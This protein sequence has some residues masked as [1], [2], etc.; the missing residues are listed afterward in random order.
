MWAQNHA[1]SLQSARRRQVL[2]QIALSR[3][4]LA[5]STLTAQQPINNVARV[6]L[7]A[8]AAVLGGTQ[9]LHTNSMDEALALPSQTAAQV[10]LRTQ[11]IIAY[12]TGVAD[13]IDPLAGS[14][15]I[16]SL[17]DQLEARAKA[18]IDQIDALGGALVAIE[19]GFIQQQIQDS[20]YA[21]QQAVERGD[22][23][24]VG[25]NLY[26]DNKPPAIELLRVDP[27]IEQGQRDRLAA[28]RARRD[29]SK[30]SE[31]LSH[32]ESAARG[33]DPLLPLFITAVEADVTLGEIC[34]ALRHVFGEYI[35]P[36]TL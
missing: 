17:T 22:Q 15:L 34:H 20:A 18:L 27:A 25:L 10:A 7:Q 14:Y 23:K 11:Q 3:R 6:A 31:L 5:G 16:E 13:S 36:I 30:V 9:S 32:I 1:R 35:P 24:I 2:A 21:Y 12:E 4:K 28:V 19:R 26:S 29:P 33:T 8:M